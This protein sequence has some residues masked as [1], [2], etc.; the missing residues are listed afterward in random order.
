V[1]EHELKIENLIQ[2]T[3]VM[4]SKAESGDWEDVIALENERSVLMNAYFSQEEEKYSDDVTAIRVG[5]ETIQLMDEQ[6]MQLGN[7]QK[8]EL[9]QALQEL[10]QG[11]KAVNAY[12]H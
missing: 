6:L 3:Q 5:I 7:L 12:S 1:S 10:G 9:S 8:K 2:L 11:K 4:L